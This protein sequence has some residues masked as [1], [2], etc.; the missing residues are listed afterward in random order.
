M[1]DCRR[2]SLTVAVVAAIA[3]SF[4]AAGSA[5]ETHQ[6]DVRARISFVKHDV[7]FRKLRLAITRDDAV[8]R[9]GPLGSAFIVRPQVHVRDLDLDGEPE[10]WVDIY[11]GGAHCCL[12][13]R[14]FRWLPSRGAYAS[15]TH[16]WR[17]VGYERTRLDGDAR[18]ELVS[19]DARFG[20][21]FTS[22]A[23]SAFPVQ[24]WHFDHGRIIDV[25][26]AFP[27]EI[28][29]DANQLWRSY[30]RFRT[31]RD[32]PRGVLAAWVADEFLLGRGDE[33]WAT[34]RRLAKRGAFGPRPDLAGWPQGGAYLRALHTFLRKSG[35]LD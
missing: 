31:G 17:D 33:G 7:E 14:F 5:R 30:R 11:S 26:R 27:S 4:A 24:I 34:L 22:F 15:T 9:S 25:T 35:Y 29:R 19:A 32:D 2:R 8:W 13:S 20:Y 3:L 18:P 28:E 23:G 10:V 21:M 1:A 12:D 6:I 16:A